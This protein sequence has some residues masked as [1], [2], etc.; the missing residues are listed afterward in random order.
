M[1]KTA[2]NR[3]WIVWEI[4]LAISKKEA[5]FEKLFNV[6]SFHCMNLDLFIY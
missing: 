3:L 4:V 6:D 5:P 2:G 1:E